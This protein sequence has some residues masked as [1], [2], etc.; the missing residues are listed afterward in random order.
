MLTSCYEKKL[1]CLDV[2]ATNYDFAADAVCEDDCC[3]YPALNISLTHTFN[4][5]SFNLKD[6]LINNIGDTLIL[7]NQKWYL[8]ELYLFTDRTKLPLLQSEVLPL[9][10]SSDST[11]EKSYKLIRELSS[12]ATIN[13]IK[14]LDT[15]KRIKVDIGLPPV[16]DRIQTARVASGSDFQESTGMSDGNG[17][18]YSYLATI[19]AGKG[20]KDTVTCY[21][22][23]H[24]EKDITLFPSIKQTPGAPINLSLKFKYENLF[25]DIGF[26]S[27]SGTEINSVLE[28]NLE[29]FL[30]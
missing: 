5:F 23:G 9:I 17:R 16:F 6:T 1:G 30:E 7:L 21:A 26:Q 28:K 3:K 10:N 12:A 27:M 25:K 2:Y 11:F 19:I 14:A 8:S 18:Y 22:Y 15:I 20:L 4:D 13:S 29:F 24:F